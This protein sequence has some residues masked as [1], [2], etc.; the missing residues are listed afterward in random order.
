ME[1]VGPTHAVAYIHQT[2]RSTEGPWS[3]RVR[4]HITAPSQDSHMHFSGSASRERAHA[5]E[6]RGHEPPGIPRC[7]AVCVD[8][9]ERE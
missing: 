9:V 8:G 2:S 1:D 5:V 7:H 6:K 4:I 3:T